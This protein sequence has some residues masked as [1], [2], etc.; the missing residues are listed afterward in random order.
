MQRKNSTLVKRKKRAAFALIMAIAVIVIISTI[1]ALSLSITAQTTKKTADLYL[2][3]QAML[4]AKSAEGYQLL[5]IAQNPPC[6]NLDTTFVQDIYY[7]I[8]I[9]SRY[10]YENTDTPDPCAAVG[11]TGTSYTT[12]ATPEQDGSVLIDVA[13][14]VNDPSLSTEQIRYFRRTIQKL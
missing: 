11:A 12:V 3:E 10:V 14:S 9:T 13:V 7:T 1:L 4:L 5:R 2:Y 6:T 8:D